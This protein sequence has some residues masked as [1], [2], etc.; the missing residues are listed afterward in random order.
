MILN[1]NHPQN[2][3]EI[4]PKFLM[5]LRGVIDSTDIPLN[6]SRS[7]LLSNRTVRRIADYIA[8]K[9]GDRLKELYR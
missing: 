3:E 8:K 1:L 4:I 2:I 9:V 7:S 5:P 6:V